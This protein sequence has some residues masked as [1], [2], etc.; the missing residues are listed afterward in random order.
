[1]STNEP[2]TEKNDSRQTVA[3]DSSAASPK[4]P[5]YIGSEHEYVYSIFRQDGTPIRK[6]IWTAVVM[7]LLLIPIIGIM[8]YP[9][10]GTVKIVFGP[11]AYAFADAL[12][13]WSIIGLASPISLIA[14]L[15]IPYVPGIIL[16]RHFRDAVI[17]MCRNTSP[18]NEIARGTMQSLH[19][20]LVRYV[21]VLLPGIIVFLVPVVFTLGFFI[22]IFCDA[23]NTG[24]E[25]VIIHGSFSVIVWMYLLSIPGWL[26]SE[27]AL[28]IFPVA[29]L[30][31]RLSGV[32]RPGMFLILPL[33]YLV[34]IVFVLNPV[35]T[36]E[37]TAFLTV[38]VIVICTALSV[39]AIAYF[40]HAA[41]TDAEKWDLK[42]QE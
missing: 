14:L 37:R 28:A 11:Q 3:P 17:P 34:R 13:R 23:Q 2:L 36:A 21:L 7:Q 33:I 20:M 8:P 40:N 24:G 16:R 5:L 19:Y 22:K 6:M 15:A 39:G 38:A 4:P 26:L 9:W 30:F 31:T 42:D 41:K 27:Y 29:R 1:M 25:L 35:F 10:K 32:I 18:G 12:E